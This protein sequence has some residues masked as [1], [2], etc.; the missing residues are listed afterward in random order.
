VN[1]HFPLIAVSWQ[2]QKLR[3]KIILNLIIGTTTTA[4]TTIHAVSLPI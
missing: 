2:I 4:A 1:A 3:I